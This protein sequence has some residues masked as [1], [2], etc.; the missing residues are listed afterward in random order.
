MKL[1]RDPFFGPVKNQKGFSLVVAAI[2]I[3]CV[4]ILASYIV[5]ISS[6]MSRFTTNINVVSNSR[7]IINILTGIIS[8]PTLCTNSLPTGGAL[9]DSAAAHSQDGMTMAINVGSNLG[10]ITDGAD[11]PV[12]NL[13]VKSLRFKVLGAPTPD[14][15][16]P[17]N[18]LYTGA[19]Y[20]QMTKSGGLIAYVGGNE[21]KEKIISN[22]VLSVV[23]T[24]NNIAGCYALSGAKQACV[25]LG[26]TYSPTSTPQCKLPYPCPGSTGKFF[27]GYDATTGSPHCVSASEMTGLACPDANNFLVSNGDGTSRCQSL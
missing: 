3:A 24:T 15:A 25:D 17:G 5:D 22:M 14:L 10:V 19:L 21:M 6:A 20:I 23:P 11:L 4:T 9:Y 18:L 7:G 12:Y 1:L 26:G 8:Y 2:T 13:K 16:N 27:A